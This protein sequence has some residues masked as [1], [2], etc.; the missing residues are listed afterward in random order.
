MISCVQLQI[1][2]GNIQQAKSQLLAKSQS[3]TTSQSD[4]GTTT[5]GKW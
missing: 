5:S 1:L 2:L 3:H 4:S